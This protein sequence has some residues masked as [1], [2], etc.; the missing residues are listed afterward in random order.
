MLTSPWIRS[1]SAGGL[2]YALRPLIVT[3]G[4]AGQGPADRVTPSH[5]YTGVGALWIDDTFLCTASR[6][7]ERTIL[8]AAHCLTD[9]AGGVSA[10]R[11][12]V[13]FQSPDGLESHAIAAIGPHSVHPGYTGDLFAGF[14]VAVLELA[15]APSSA[16][17]RYALHR[18]EGADIGAAFDVVGYGRS[19]TGAIGDQLDTGTKRDGRNRFDDY[20]YLLQ[21]FGTTPEA[22]VTVLMFDFD[23]GLAGNDA[24]GFFLGDA[25]ADTGFPDEVF[26]APG[27]SGG[28]SFIDGRIA[29][30]TSFGL[31]LAYIADGASSDID[32]DL[33]ST[34]GEFAG[35][36]RIA[37]PGIHAWIDAQLRIPG[38]NSLALLLLGLCV[39]AACRRC[40]PAASAA[41]RKSLDRLRSRSLSL[42]LW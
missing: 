42:S 31:R 20:G 9:S 4:G 34:F 7:G 26:T 16:V 27:D 2:E 18:D 35:A 6:I 14:D 39:V 24:F 36:A 12:T 29:G 28:P 3:Q 30:V 23:N 10:A 13:F 33:N 17:A 25:F 19:G 11:A 15:S 1:G 21:L 37:N 22:A 38:P 8:T 5:S 32:Q 40:R 41:E